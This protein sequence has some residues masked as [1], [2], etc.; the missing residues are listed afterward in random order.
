[1]T[2]TSSDSADL[3]EASRRRLLSIAYRMLGSVSEAEDIVQE[4]WIRWHEA[5]CGQLESPVAWL[6]TVATRL[7]IDRL[8]RL[9]RER[10]AMLGPWL[11]EPWLGDS[12]PSAED[13][14]SMLSDLSYS[15]LLLLERL[16]PDE[17]AALLLHEVFDCPYKEIA[18]TLN[19]SDA[20]CRQLVHRAKERVQSGRTRRIVNDE[21]CER[22]VQ[23]FLSAIRNLDKQAMLQLIAKE[24]SVI[25]DSGGGTPIACLAKTQSAHSFVGALMSLSPLDLQIESICINGGWGAK[26]YLRGHLAL[27][28]SFEMDR[29]GIRRIYAVG[30]PGKLNGSVRRELGRYR[31]SLYAATAP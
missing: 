10:S 13:A 17:R 8:R 11:P 12:A 30:H 31:P 24:A 6:T 28:L 14:A 23:D 4:T 1:M 27:A 21:V 19:K 20:H 5:E 29:Q 26:V 7:S 15:V 3:F 9:Q 16:S 25:G 18:R 22:M 2:K